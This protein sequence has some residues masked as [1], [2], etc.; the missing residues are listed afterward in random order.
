MNK[1]DIRPD[2]FKMVQDILNKSLSSDVK[3]WVYGSRAKW[4]TLDSSDLDL[5]LEGKDKIDYEVINCLNRDFEES[6]LPY[7]VDVVDINTV[8]PFFRDIINKDKVL[9]DRYTPIKEK[10]VCSKRLAR[11]EA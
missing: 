5:A 10:K 1:P 8:Q 4:T 3:V 7:E 9:L 6:N 2:H 11:S